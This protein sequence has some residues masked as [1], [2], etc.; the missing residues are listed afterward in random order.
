M[1]EMIVPVT[2]A[3]Y[4]KAQ[5]VF[6]RA[7]DFE[8]VPV[9]SDEATLAAFIRA[10]GCGAVA[11]GVATYTGPLYDALPEYGILLRF[12]VG[13]DGLDRAQTRAKKLIIANTPGALDRSVAE[14]AIFLMGAL[15]RHLCALNQT[16][17]SGAWRPIVGSDMQ[18]LT[19]GIIGAGPIG[20][21]TAQI[22]HQ[23]FGMRTAICELQSETQVAA[24]L[25][26][27]ADDLRN[28]L[29]YGVWSADPEPALAQA[30]VVSAHLPLL[31]STR[32]FFDADRFA[33][34]K[35]G[36][37]FINTARGGLVVET[38]LAAALRN[39]KLAGAALDVFEREPYAPTAPEADLRQLD[40]ALLTP[41]VGSN[42]AGAN[43]RMAELVA[44]NLRHW[45]NGELDRISV[46][47]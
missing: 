18:D 4:R 34:F 17:H 16:A 37:L 46:V 39:G 35:D 33:Q 43:R 6:E 9:S 45:A 15:A 47:D 32:G 20:A 7:R 19:L 28:L 14:H 25:G 21:M 40:N 36:S 3:E 22:A 42:T 44:Q 13:T 27:S 24:R 11:L 12:G 26:T 30:D 2:E 31:P 10:H 38:D 29:G 8:F 23:G 5:T 1:C 41:H